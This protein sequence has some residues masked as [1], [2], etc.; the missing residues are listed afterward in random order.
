MQ[1]NFLKISQWKDRDSRKLYINVSTMEL[2]VDLSHL[3]PKDVSDD[4]FTI[5]LIDT[6]GMDSAQS[7]KNGNN[8]HAE[9]ALEAIGMDSKPMILLC[10][11][12]NIMK[13]RVLANLCAK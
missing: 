5:V 11:D 9:T 8:R 3:Y 10:A 12:A 2:E 4:K 7:S 13:I 6:P 1:K